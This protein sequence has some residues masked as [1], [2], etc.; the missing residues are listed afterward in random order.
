MCTAVLWRVFWCFCSLWARA[1]SPP[2][3][4]R[5]V[6]GLAGAHVTLV[7]KQPSLGGNSAKATSGIN[8]ANT[9]YQQAKGIPDT[10]DKFKY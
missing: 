4:R 7:D 9:W 5:P 1:P 3:Q 6:L 2:P 10:P 8:G